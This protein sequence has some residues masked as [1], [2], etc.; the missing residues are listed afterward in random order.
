M[1]WLPG[2]LLSFLLKALLYVAINYLLPGVV[3]RFSYAARVNLS[4]VVSLVM[5]LAVDALW[6]LLTFLRYYD[7]TVYVGFSL[8]R[9]LYHAVDIIGALLSGSIYS[10]DHIIGFGLLTLASNILLF[11]FFF[12]RSLRKAA[13]AE[14]SSE[15]SAQ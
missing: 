11:A 2:F 8:L 5:L 9:M 12:K 3:A 4:I 10:N 7:S 15:E 6:Y 13:E 1:H 14:A